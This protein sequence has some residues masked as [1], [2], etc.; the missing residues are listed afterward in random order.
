MCGSCNTFEGKSTPRHFLEDKEG[1]ALHLLE[2]RGCP[3][4]QTPPGRYH[5]GIV[6]KH[7]EA[8]ERHRHRSRPYRG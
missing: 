8:S 6:Q 1:A 2:C 7:L 3:E 4:G 5:V